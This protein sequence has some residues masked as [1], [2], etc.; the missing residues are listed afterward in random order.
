MTLQ[1]QTV[2][3]GT[4]VTAGSTVDLTTALRGDSVAVNTVLSEITS[5]SSP[6]TAEYVIADGY[7]GSIT[8]YYAKKA[9]PLPLLTLCNSYDNFVLKRTYVTDTTTKTLTTFHVRAGLSS[10]G[11]GKGEQVITLQL[12]SAGLGHT[13]A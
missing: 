13:W 12:G 2:S 10:D 3:A 1:G 11:S 8:L 9:D 4:Y 5:D 6:L 7:S